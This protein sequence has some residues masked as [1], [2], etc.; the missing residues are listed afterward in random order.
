ML[1]VSGL[2][3]TWA[4]VM[5]LRIAKRYEAAGNRFSTYAVR[6]QWLPLLF[7]ALFGFG[8]IAAIS[9]AVRHLGA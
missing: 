1:I 6:P 5:L 4:S 8:A 9:G 7:T 3:L 2:G